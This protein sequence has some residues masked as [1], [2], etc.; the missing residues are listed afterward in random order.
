[1]VHEANR[2]VYGAGRDQ[3]V[4]NVTTGSEQ[5]QESR[6]RR[7]W[8]NVPARNPAFTGREEL[9]AVVRRALLSTNR[10]VVQALNG[11]GGVG[12][13]Q[14]AIEYAHRFASGYDVVWWVNADKSG[15]IGEQF[16]AL[17]GELGCAVSA[18]S[19][20]EIQRAAL[21]S[22]RDTERWLLIF[23]NAET[24][25]DIHGWLPGGAGH[26]LI[27]SRSR[28]WDEVAVPIEIDVL[29]RDESV[30]MLRRRARGLSEA[31]ASLVAEAVGDLPLAVSQAVGY[32][33]ETGM[34]AASYVRLLGDRAGEVLDQGRP[35]S[36]RTSL[37]AVTVLALERLRAENPAAADLAVICAFLAP[38]PIPADWFAQAAAELPAALAGRAGDP[39]AWPLVLARLGQSA[40]ARVERDGLRMH[41]LT[42]AI[43]RSHLPSDRA[44]ETRGMAEE[45][46][47][48]N[49]PGD[50]DAPGR[51]PVWARFLP[52]LLAVDPGISDNADL[53]RAATNAARYLR[54]RGDA[55]ASQDLSSDLYDRWRDRLGIDDDLTLQAAHCLAAAFRS[56]GRY[57]EAR[58]LDQDTLA[59]R[60]RALG[61]DHPDTLAS[62]NNLAVGLKDQGDLEGARTLHEDTLARRRRV[63]G[64][65]HRDTLHSAT[66]LAVVLRMLGSWGAARVLE[67]DTRARHRRVLGDDHPD[68]LRSA[69][70]LATT[71]TR[72]RDYGAARVLDEDTLARR[73]RVLGDDHPDTLRSAHNLATT[74]TRLG[75]Y[76][77]ARV[78]DED[79]LARR[80]R[81]LGENHPDTLVSANNLAVDLRDLGDFHAAQE[82]DE[83]T[84]ARRRRVL[85]DDHADTKESARNLASDLRALGEA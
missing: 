74:L 42:Q 54:L 6:R 21:M 58:E 29:T 52:H 14:L 80:R 37:A 27:T 11:M 24:P 81:V 35:S 67:G 71:L 13:T 36:Y 2:D 3:V 20:A 31:E 40:L 8:G 19:L 39:V 59:R 4:V 48:A 62:A 1:M 49:A 33:A 30:A 57:S 82:M 44:D 7:I 12:K 45:I 23:D 66:N 84:L 83:D 50:T 55:R 69:H 34:S 77:A 68:T 73:R 25:E 65:D 32:M 63:L 16:A 76:G 10:T 43:I 5:G 56:T 72:L 26:V 85:G 79:T 46:L 15:L 38:E 9:L 17:A 61:D 53:R 41:R 47:A 51:W 18:A 22:L 28:G 70:N 60:R 64:D 75:D 78:L